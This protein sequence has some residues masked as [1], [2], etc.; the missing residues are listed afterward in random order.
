MVHGLREVEVANARMQNEHLQLIIYEHKTG[1]L[2]P[3]VVY[4]EKLSSQ[5]LL[6]F[7]ITIIPMG[8][9]KLMGHFLF[10]KEGKR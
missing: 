5:A 8:I 10:L 4:L 9:V 3:A 6:N 2:K 7:L 1:K